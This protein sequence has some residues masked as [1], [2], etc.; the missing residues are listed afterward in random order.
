MSE[1]SRACM[2]T[3]LNLLDDLMRQ[4][5]WDLIDMYLWAICCRHLEHPFQLG[6]SYLSLTLPAKEHLGYRGNLY[7]AMVLRAQV[8]H[9][10]EWEV[11]M[12]GLK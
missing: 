5:E 1:F 6:L 7:K 8:E 10:N 3:H 9:P 4:G 2:D 11:I 12:K